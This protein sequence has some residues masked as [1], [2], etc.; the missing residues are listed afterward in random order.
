MGRA[1]KVVGWFF[2]IIVFLFGLIVFASVLFRLEYLAGPLLA[3]L[4]IML[5]GALLCYGGSRA[6]RKQNLVYHSGSTSDTIDNLEKL[7]R[8]K[9]VPENSETKNIEPERL[10]IERLAAERLAAERLAKQKKKEKFRNNIKRY[11][12]SN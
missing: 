5:I 3:G 6:G 7:T 4:V 10:A 12:A 1:L 2:G 8:N 9:I 11:L